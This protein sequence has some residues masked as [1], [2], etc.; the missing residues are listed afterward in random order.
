MTRLTSAVCLLGCVCLAGCG[1][2]RPSLVNA[3]GTVT[4]DG[5]PVE[6]AIVSFKPVV[7][8]GAAYQRP[9]NGV[10]DSAGQFVMMTYEKGDGLPEGKYQVGIQK[11]EV[12]GELPKNYNDETP[13]QFSVRYRWVTPRQYADPA[14]SGLTAEVTSS[15]IEPPVFELK[16]SGKPEIELTGPAARA[17]EP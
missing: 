3:T 16:S 14:S 6:G 13:D 11:R 2:G 9:S 8:E 1:D 17:N 15:G 10:T 7:E 4:L 5:E 12:V